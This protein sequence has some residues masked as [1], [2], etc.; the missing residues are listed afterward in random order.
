MP[1][2]NYTSVLSNISDLNPKPQQAEGL[3]PEPHNPPGLCRFWGAVWVFCVSSELGS[4]Q[5]WELLGICVINQPSHNMSP[6][7]HTNSS[8]TAG[9]WAEGENITSCSQGGK[10]SMKGQGR[11]SRE[12]WQGT[13]RRFL[14]KW[15]LGRWG[16]QQVR[17][18]CLSMRGAVLVPGIPWHLLSYRL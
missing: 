10:N 12:R 11:D 13:K 6:A 2:C 18:S 3:S 9:E 7:L 15:S 1:V 8:A 5:L 14:E 4:N 16:Q 17:W